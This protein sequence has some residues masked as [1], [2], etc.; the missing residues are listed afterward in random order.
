MESYQGFNDVTEP[1]GILAPLEIFGLPSQFEL[2]G[3]DFEDR[4]IRDINN[5]KNIPDFTDDVVNMCVPESRAVQKD[6]CAYGYVCGS[7]LTMCHWNQ[8]NPASKFPDIAHGSK[9]IDDSGLFRPVTSPNTG[10]GFVQPNT[11]YRAFQSMED[12]YVQDGFAQSKTAS[13]AN[14]ESPTKHSLAKSHKPNV[15][16]CRVKNK[17]RVD[18]TQLFRTFDINMQ[19]VKKPH[20]RPFTQE[21]RE[22]TNAVR[23]IGAC[24]TCRARHRKCRHVLSNNAVA[25]TPLGKHEALTPP[26]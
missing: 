18:K 15:K 19:P 24:P 21:E 1:L 7:G 20:R 9:M 2:P 16:G 4:S 14:T 11:P 12:L 5:L 25:E 13:E 26:P 22:Q 3:I 6:G 8:A 23:E 10:D 17:S